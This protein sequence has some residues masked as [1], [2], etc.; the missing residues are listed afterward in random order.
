MVS[1]ISESFA[2]SLQLSIRPL[3]NLLHVEGAGGH[4]LHYMGYV[5][6]QIEC[7]ELSTEA[8]NSLFLVVPDTTYHSRVPVLLGTNILCSGMSV[9]PELNAQTPWHFA[10]QSLAS[11]RKLEARVGSPGQVKTTKAVT[12]PADGSLTVHGFTRVAATS[13]MRLNVMME[14]PVMSRLPGGIVLTP[15]LRHLHP[16]RSTKRVS[17]DVK[18]CSSHPITI[19]SKS[20]LCDL[21]QVSVIPHCSYLTADVE[22]V[23]DGGTEKLCS[24]FTES[25][26]LHYL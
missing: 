9:K 15:G 4:E 16:G 17:V 10:F 21:Y 14:E 13:C 7:A 24:K 6:A 23:Q 18:N 12:V 22:Y 1:T 3:D 25:L 8:F 26:A 5:E 20:V 19:P 2:R 11:Q